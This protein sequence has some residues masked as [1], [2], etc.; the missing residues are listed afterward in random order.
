MATTKKEFLPNIQGKAFI[1]SYPVENYEGLYEYVIKANR[2]CDE[3]SGKWQ[4]STE[5]LT[6]CDN[7]ESDEIADLFCTAYNLKYPVKNVNDKLFK[8]KQAK[9][10]YY[11]GGIRAWKHY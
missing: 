5:I 9:N 8:T 10:L 3:G 2:L 11:I 6:I 1:V 7:I 4:V